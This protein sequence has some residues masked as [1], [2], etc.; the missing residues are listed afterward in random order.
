MKICRV[1]LSFATASN[2]G[3]SSSN[4]NETVHKNQAASGEVR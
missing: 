3:A 1:P 2:A 4:A